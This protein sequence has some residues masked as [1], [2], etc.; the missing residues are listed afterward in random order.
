MAKITEIPKVKLFCAVIY[1]S[2]EKLSLALQKL[3]ETYGEI[4]FIGKDFN[5]DKTDYYTP[6]MGD[7]LKR[8]LIS[9]KNCIEPDDISDIKIFTNDLEI[10]L[11]E[12]NK[13]TVN[14]DPGYL[15][16]MKVILASAKYGPHKIYL[17]NGIYADLTLIYSKGIFSDFQWTFPDFKTD[18]YRKELLEMRNIYK[19]QIIKTTKD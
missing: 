16:Y 8:K 19:K 14:I 2:H 1:Q 9:F 5:F 3:T 18:L 15:D 4:D 11:S 6:E 12:N 7:G 17:K 13:R 10:A